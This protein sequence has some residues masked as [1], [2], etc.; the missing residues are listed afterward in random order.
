MW[1][2]LKRSLK[3]GRDTPLTE[4]LSAVVLG[5][6]DSWPEQSLGQITETPKED[7]RIITMLKKIFLDEY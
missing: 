6:V 2:E 4:G 1:K 3:K 7:L 5:P